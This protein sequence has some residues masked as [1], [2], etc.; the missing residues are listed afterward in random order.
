MK[1]P[2]HPVSDHAVLRYLERRHGL[3]VESVRR[4]LGH[5]V[6]AACEGQSGMSAAVI[7]GMRFVIS[8]EGVVVTAMHKNLPE[9]GRVGRRGRGEE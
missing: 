2:L 9:R 8:A 3:D 6:E 4:E 5:R 7:D 1:K